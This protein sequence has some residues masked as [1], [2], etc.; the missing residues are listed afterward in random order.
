M[1]PILYQTLVEGTVPSDY[2]LGVLSDCI[3]CQVTEERNGP[4][5]LVMT[6]ASE[7]I[8]AEDILVN[9]FIKVKPNFSDNPQLFRIYKVGKTINGHFTVNA[10]HISYDLGGKVATSGSANSCADA[11]ILLT[12]NFAGAFNITTDKA[13]SNYFNI[14]EPSSVRSWFGG[15]KGSLLDVYGEGEWHYDNY[16]A[17]LK[18]HR[19]AD[20]GVEIR[21]GKNLTELSQEINI[22]SLVTAIIPYAINPDTGLAAIG[23]SH[24]TGLVLDTPRELAM[25]FG[26]SVDWEDSTPVTTQ[27]DNLCANYITRNVGTLINLKTTITLGFVQLSTLQDRVDLCDTVHIYFEALGISA[28]MKCIATTWDV[29][30]ERYTSTTFGDPKQSITDT[31]V[32]VQDNIKELPTP[33]EVANISNV[34]ADHAT[35]LITGNLGGY[36]VV[37]DSNGDGE[38]DEVL[39]MN[40]D[41]ISTATK[42]WRW[43]S[44]GLGYSSTGYAGTYG[45]AMTADGEIV[46][47]FITTGTLNA[48]LIKAGKITDVL[49]NSEINLANGDAKMYNMSAV[50]GFHLL[51]EGKTET[52]ATF[53]A[54]LRNTEIAMAA[55]DATN[56]FIDLKATQLQGTDTD[57]AIITLKHLGSALNAILMATTTGGK[58]TLHDPNEVKTVDLSNIPLTSGYGGRLATYNSNGYATFFGGCAN[59]GNGSM[60]VY[61]ASQAQKVRNNINAFGRGEIN[62][63]DE[64]GINRVTIY[65]DGGLVLKD[66]GGNTCIDLDGSNKKIIADKMSVYE[67]TDATIHC[68]GVWGTIDDFWV[69]RMGNV[70]YMKLILLGN[71][72]S[73]SGGSNGCTGTLSGIDLPL[74]DTKLVEYYQNNMIIMTLKTDGTFVVRNIGSALAVAVGG[75]IELSGSFIVA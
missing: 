47:D 5:E 26:D 66:A 17:M 67:L 44:A 32:E 25:D 51:D 8:H 64:N 1:K 16:T 74:I 11:C 72:S 12:N 59:N 43:N 27:L 63:W 29:L 36:V 37:H 21:Y 75:K 55:Q 71:G 24:S 38:P 42:V 65:G 23:S 33:K 18:L 61:N 19:G 53:R 13:V 39:I 10:Q 60:T 50:Y 22:E 69:Y 52:R 34:I 2:G 68:S 62:L 3:S 28:A 73:V 31:I 9:R 48:D 30:E 58:F 45:L 54:N 56:P 20:R 14:S 15:K 57:S 40:T 41:D 46:A 70:V 6:Y 7:G 35:Q 4:Y 49:G